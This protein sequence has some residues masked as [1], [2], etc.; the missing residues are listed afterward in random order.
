MTFYI[1]MIIINNIINYLNYHNYLEGFY[2]IIIC[3]LY[4]Y[5]FYQSVMVY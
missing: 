2:I 1:I 4:N 3:D 5:Y